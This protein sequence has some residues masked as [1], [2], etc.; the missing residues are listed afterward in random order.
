M[1]FCFQD[2]MLK[3]CMKAYWTNLHTRLRG[4]F[5]ISTFLFFGTVQPTRI[6]EQHKML[7]EMKGI[8]NFSNQK[9]EFEKFANFSNFFLSNRTNFKLKFIEFFELCLPF[10]INRIVNFRIELTE[11]RTNPSLTPPLL[12]PYLDADFLCI[13]A[14]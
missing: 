12:L 11:F 6:I 2:R 8:S 9:T 4:I 7:F 1:I 5:D 3:F 10:R 14:S 13:Q